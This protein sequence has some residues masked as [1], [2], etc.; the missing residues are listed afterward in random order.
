MKIFLISDKDFTSCLLNCSNNGICHPEGYCHCNKDYTGSNCELDLNQCSSYP[1]IN[2]ST[3][4]DINIGNNSSQMLSRNYTCNCSAYFYGKNCEFEI[5]VC[6]NERCNGNGYCFKNNSI[7]TCN[8]SSY[9]SGAKCEVKLQ[10]LKNLETVRSATVIITIISIISFILYILFLDF[11][12]SSVSKKKR[13][14]SFNKTNQYLK[15]R[16]KWTHLE[17][18]P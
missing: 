18:I 1:C 10:E 13:I 6:K 2:N 11:G 15:E 7:P 12:P 3:C 17:Y 4:Y 5:D 8:C 16:K 14:K 9:Y